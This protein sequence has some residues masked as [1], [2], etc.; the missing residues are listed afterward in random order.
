M[1]INNLYIEILIWLIMT[2]NFF[3]RLFEGTRSVHSIRVRCLVSLVLVQTHHLLQLPVLRFRRLSPTLSLF[4]ESLR[5]LLLVHHRFSHRFLGLMCHPRIMIM[6]LRR[7]L[8]H[9]R[10][11]RFIPIF[12]CRRVLLML[13]TP[14]RT[15]SLNQ[16]YEVYHS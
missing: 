16:A 7:H 12:W 5:R 11:T 14:L 15:F 9:W 3:S 8:L 2:I 13:C 1:L 10:R 4:R 6:F